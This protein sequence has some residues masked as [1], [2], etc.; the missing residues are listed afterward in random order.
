LDPP[1][2]ATL[3]SGSEGES[4]GKITSSAASYPLPALVAAS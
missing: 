4:V 2:F 1:T 3:R